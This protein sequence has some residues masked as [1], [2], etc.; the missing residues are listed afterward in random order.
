[1]QRRSGSAVQYLSSMVCQPQFNLESVTVLVS[2]GILTSAQE[3]PDRSLEK[4]DRASLCR[5]KSNSLQYSSLLM[6]T[7][8]S[9]KAQPFTMEQK[10]KHV[11]VIGELNSVLLCL[12][13]VQMFILIATRDS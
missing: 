6:Q 11:L 2:H 5:H 12:Q 3:L 10:A 9:P 8:P 7:W 1:M 4:L 13:A